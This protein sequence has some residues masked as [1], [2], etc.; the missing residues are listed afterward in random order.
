MDI[1]E[2][3]AL[4]AKTLISMQ[5]GKLDPA[6]KKAVDEALGQFNRPISDWMQDGKLNV[7]PNRETIL[8]GPPESA[9]GFGASR[10]VD[11]YSAFAPQSGITELYNLF[12]AEMEKLKATL[13]KTSTKPDEDNEKD[14]MVEKAVAT[15]RKARKLISKIEDE[16]SEEEIESSE[17]DELVEKAR[18]LLEKAKSYLTKAEDAVEDDEDEGV[19]KA[20]K[21][22]KSLHNR[23]L[24]VT[25]A[26]K[27]IND[28]K[29][30][31]VKA[32]K[33]ALEKAEKEKADKEKEEKDKAEKEAKDKAEKEAKE[34]ED[35]E[36]ANQAAHQNPD[37]GN[38]G[39]MDGDLHMSTKSL[40]EFITGLMAAHRV[41]PA[42]NMQK[43][44]A[45]SID[46]AIDNAEDSG[47]LTTSETVEAR[48]ILNRLALLKSG[49]IK[50]DL[51][52]ESLKKMSPALTKFF[53][54]MF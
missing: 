48:A 39:G 32:E 22:R 5:T 3:A 45:E 2:Q 24:D 51:F 4:V 11:Q 12:T 10:M 26:R 28:A 53:R 41:N 37:N 8:F 43:S 52:A 49:S 46:T 14:E 7:V 30:A 35:L 34:K 9:S 25:A 54:D 19:E 1:K 23:L 38:Q 15:L 16:D 44:G 18:K 36:K 13:G 33:D 27:A 20:R 29:L 40:N 47:M 42:I 50:Q 17:A 31:T 21:I 6:F